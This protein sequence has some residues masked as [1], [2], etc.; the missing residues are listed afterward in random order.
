MIQI[1]NFQN[2]LYMTNINT[3]LFCEIIVKARDKPV[4][5]DLCNKWIHIKC[6]IFNDLDY[7]NLTPR[8]ESCYCK[9]CIQEILPFCSKKITPNNINSEHSSIDPNLK[10]ILCYLNNLSE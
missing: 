1:S 6:N 4:C 7:E 8:N 3:C 9:A 10:K 5:C 2:F